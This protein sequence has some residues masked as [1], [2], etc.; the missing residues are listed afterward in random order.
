MA[1]PCSLWNE[2]AIFVFYAVLLL[3]HD[4]VVVSETHEYLKLEEVLFFISSLLRS[5]RS[6]GMRTRCTM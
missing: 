3:F 2:A 5:V 6:L 1:A 4:S